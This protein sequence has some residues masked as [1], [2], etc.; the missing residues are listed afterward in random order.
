MNKRFLMFN[1]LILLTLGIA[2]LQA[3]EF[4][5]LSHKKSNILSDRSH[6]QSIDWQD[7]FD[8]FYNDPV[9]TALIVTVLG[10]TIWGTKAPFPSNVIHFSSNQSYFWELGEV[11]SGVPLSFFKYDCKSVNNIVLTEPL[12]QIYFH[13]SYTF[14]DTVFDTVYNLVIQYNK[15]QI[16]VDSVNL[17]PF[18]GQTVVVNSAEDVAFKLSVTRSFDVPYINDFDKAKGVIMSHL[19]TDRSD[20]ITFQEF[21]ID[22]SFVQHL[23]TNDSLVPGYNTFQFQAVGNCLNCQ[24]QGLGEEYSDPVSLKV[25]YLDFNGID[26]QVCREDKIYKLNGIP[27]GGYFT[28]DG[29]VDDSTLMFNPALASIGTDTLV[30]HYFIEGQEYQVAKS[31]EIVEPPDFTMS[32]E[33]ETCFNDWDIPYTITST[34]GIF[35]YIDWII[36]GGTINS[37]NGDNSEVFIH[38]KPRNQAE[39]EPFTGKITVTMSNI[40]C[41]TTKEY[42]VE[43][44]NTEA[45]DPSFMMIYNDNLLVC[46]DLMAGYFIWYYNTSQVATTNV[47]YCFL[48][49]A[50]QPV[51]GDSS[52]VYTAKDLCDTNCL[53]RSNTYIVPPKRDLSASGYQMGLPVFPNPNSGEFTILLPGNENQEY[54]LTITDMTG[55]VVYSVSIDSSISGKEYRVYGKKWPAGI[56]LL[57]LEGNS[58]SLF[59]KIMITQ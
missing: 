26:D 56:Y 29:I 9:N 46:D 31:I 6:I 40:L 18:S 19:E 11:Y 20:V 44:G 1:L 10:D 47:P 51:P 50:F 27:D 57:H 14:N 33:L 45:P 8:T 12:N 35:T 32:G 2:T 28:G 23:L 59:K 36:D 52:Y 7:G 41:S 25:F 55:R 38:W 48:G 30:Y 54:L 24:D 17:L 49:E 5:F 53:T 16:H 42:L 4:D 3:Q 13:T 21:S 15:P 37:A 58:S 34:A 39:N 22:I 43:L